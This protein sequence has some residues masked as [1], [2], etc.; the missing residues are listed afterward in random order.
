[1]TVP[2]AFYR[3]AASCFDASPD[4]TW[5]EEEILALGIENLRSPADLVTVTDF[6]TNLLAGNTSDAELARL[7]RGTSAGIAFSEG[8]YRP[9]FTLMGDMLRNEMERRNLP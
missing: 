7:W 5:S 4:Y 6:V 9:F 3:F 1:M 8:A 2:A